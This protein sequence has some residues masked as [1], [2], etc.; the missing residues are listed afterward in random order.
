VPGQPT[1]QV[2]RINIK[3]RS[4]TV[5]WSYSLGSDE[6]PVGFFTLQYENSTFKGDI[7]LPGG[8]SSKELINLKPYTSYNVRVMAKSILGEGAWS[9][10]VTFTTLT[11]S[12]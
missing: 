6:T 8:L 10:Q 9:N 4:T 1:V 11:T 7:T 2:N 3:A 12:K 5:T